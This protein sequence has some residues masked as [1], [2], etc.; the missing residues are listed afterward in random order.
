MITN[1]KS[2]KGFVFSYLPSIK[3]QIYIYVNLLFRNKPSRGSVVRLYVHSGI[4]PTYSITSQNLTLK[5]LSKFLK[6]HPLN[7]GQ[8]DNIFPFIHY[9]INVF[10][11]FP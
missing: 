11:N 10:N 6:T 3:V 5:E 1:Y 7:T 9:F 8:L 4:L 2:I